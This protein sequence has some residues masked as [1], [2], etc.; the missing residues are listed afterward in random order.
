MGGHAWSV[1][2]NDAECERG[3]KSEIRR[4]W[5]MRLRAAQAA[6]AVRGIAGKRGARKRRAKILL[7]PP[8]CTPY[9]ALYALFRD[10]R[11]DDPSGG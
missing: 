1:T 8:A 5:G 6:I 9:T 3:R 2:S 7:I 4:R 10:R 11:M